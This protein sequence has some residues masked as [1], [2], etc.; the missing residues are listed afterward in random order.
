MQSDLS[1]YS[2][3]QDKEKK[4]KVVNQSRQEQRNASRKKQ[5]EKRRENS[6]KIQEN[7]QKNHLSKLEESG[8]IKINLPDGT[9]IITGST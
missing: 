9:V 4:I 8:V 3:I 7:R 5:R 2:L 6:H 1:Q